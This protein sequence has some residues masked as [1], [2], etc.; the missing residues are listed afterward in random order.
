MAVMVVL[1]PSGAEVNLAWC[2]AAAT[3]GCAVAN[4]CLSHSA[5]VEAAEASMLLFSVNTVQPFWS[6]R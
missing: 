6:M 2:Q 4:S 3:Q 5:C 1:S